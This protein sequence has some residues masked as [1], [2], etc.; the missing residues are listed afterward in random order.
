MSGEN[1]RDAGLSATYEIRRLFDIDFK[2]GFLLD[3]K[4]ICYCPDSIQ[5]KS[6]CD[7]LE[8]VYSSDVDGKQL[9]E[10]ILLKC[11]I[12]VPSRANFKL[13]RPEDLIRFHS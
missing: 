4:G 13:W 5:L 2:F 9:Y 7:K 10:D 1:V 12:L 3:V 11:E 6:M 8:A